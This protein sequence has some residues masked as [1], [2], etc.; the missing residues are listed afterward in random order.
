MVEASTIQWSRNSKITVF[1]LAPTGVRPGSY[2][3]NGVVYQRD[4]GFGFDVGGNIT[5]FDPMVYVS[6]SVP[7]YIFPLKSPNRNR[8]TWRGPKPSVVVQAISLLAGSG[9][10]SPNLMMAL[11]P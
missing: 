1:G 7:S 2:S 6:C 3:N 9:T 10:M 4:T 5:D 8:G 11:R